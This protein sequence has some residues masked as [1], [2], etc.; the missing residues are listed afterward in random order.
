MINYSTT[1]NL[2]ASQTGLTLK[3]R[4]YSGGVQ[5]GADITTGFTES[6]P[7]GAY[8]FET[9]AIPD[10]FNGMIRYYDQDDNLVASEGFNAPS[11]TDLSTIEEDIGLI[12]AKT[13]LLN[14]TTMAIYRPEAI[15]GG[16]LIIRRS[17]TNTIVF[18][19]VGNI[20]DRTKL[21]FTLQLEKGSIDSQSIIQIEETEGLKVLQQNPVP[22]PLTNLDGQINVTDEELGN[23]TVTLSARAA[24]RLAV[25]NYGNLFYDIKKITSTQSLP[26]IE[27]E[28]III[29]SITK[30]IS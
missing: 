3:A 4:L 29:N 20:Q 24:E 5:V 17:S 18:T 16:R 14:T 30:T 21:F 23:F 2:Y 22:S 25:Y 26:I 15:K 6:E 7:A 28:A 1:I 12:K 9:N 10:N 11:V 8:E 13:D 27:G 19:N